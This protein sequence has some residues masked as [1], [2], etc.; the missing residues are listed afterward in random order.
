MSLYNELNNLRTYFANY[1]YI[2]LIYLREIMND[3][4]LCSLWGKNNNSLALF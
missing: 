3:I 1:I 2:N 4:E